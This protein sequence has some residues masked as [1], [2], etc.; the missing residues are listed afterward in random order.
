MKKD[1]Q[2][3]TTGTTKEEVVEKLKLL[4]EAGVCTTDKDHCLEVEYSHYSE[5]LKSH[6]WTVNF[7]VFGTYPRAKE[8]AVYDLVGTI[9]DLMKSRKS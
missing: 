7:V 8:Y 1:S 3:I 5:M 4:A 6:I 9:V 2:F